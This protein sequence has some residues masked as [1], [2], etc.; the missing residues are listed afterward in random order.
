MRLVPRDFIEESY[1]S[2]MLQL[3]AVESSY[4]IMKKRIRTVQI[5]LVVF[6][7]VIPGIS[8]ALSEIHPSI[9]ATPARLA[10]IREAVSVPGSHHE[11]V[12]SLM[13]ERVESGDWN[14]Y[15]LSDVGIVD[16]PAYSRAFKALEASLTYLITQDQSYADIAYQSLRLIYDDPGEDVILPDDGYGLGRA[17][18]GMSFALCYDWCY[19]AWSGEQRNW[20]SGKIK[21]AINAWPSVSHTH[22]TDLS[23]TSNWV[24]V[25]RGAEMIMI[26]SLGRELYADRYRSIRGDLAIHLRNA[27]CQF[28]IT[29]E[30]LG[31]TKYGAG[32]MMLAALAAEDDGDTTIVSQ[33]RRRRL[34]MFPFYACSFRG[35][36]AAIQTGVSHLSEPLQGYLCAT[37]ETVRDTVLPYYRYMYDRHVGLLAPGE[38][39]ERFNPYR[40][41]PVWS[42]LFYNKDVEP[43]DP[44][45][46]LPRGILDGILGLGV[47][48]T[49]W[50]DEND[51]QVWFHSDWSSHTGW[52][53]PEAFTLGIMG[54]NT[55]F[56]GGP[57]T[58]FDH[59]AFSALT[60]DGKAYEGRGTNGRLLYFSVG[61]SGGYMVAD[62]AGKYD[63]LGISRVYRTFNIDLTKRSG[64]PVLM[65]TLD[66]IYDLEE[67]VYGWQLNIGTELGDDGVRVSASHEN[68]METFL[69][70]GRN[71]GW[72]KGW[73]VGPDDAEV[74]SGDPLRIVTR[75]KSK[76]IW[77]AMVVGDGPRPIARRT[78]HGL[79]ARFMVGGAAITYDTSLQR[80]VISDNRGIRLA[81]EVFE[82]TELVVEKKYG[83]LKYYEG[84]DLTTHLIES[85]ARGTVQ[86]SNDG[87]FRYMPPEDYS[88]PD[89]FIYKVE[90]SSE[91]TWVD[92]V[93]LMIEEINDPPVI[94]AQTPR[95][96][97]YPQPFVIKTEHFTIFDVDGGSEPASFIYAESPRYTMQGDTVYPHYSDS[98]D[99]VIPVRP[100]DGIDTGETFPYVVTFEDRVRAP[101]VQSILPSDTIRLIE[102]DTIEITAEAKD[103]QQFSLAWDWVRNGD[104]LLG[105]TSNGTFKLITDYPD[106][107]VDNIAVR[108]TNVAGLSTSR[109][110]TI[111]TSQAPAPILTDASPSEMTFF[112]NDSAHLWV[113]A[114][115]PRGFPLWYSW[116]KNGTD[117]L[118]STEPGTLVLVPEYGPWTHDT[119]TCIVSNPFGQSAKMN[120]ALT[121][122]PIPNPEITVHSDTYITVMEK[123]LVELSI[124]ALDPRALPLSYLWLKNGADTLSATA[125]DTYRF[126]TRFGD[127]NEDTVT[128]V[129]SNSDGMWTKKDFFITTLREPKAPVVR[130]TSAM[131]V[132]VHEGDSLNMY[133]IAEDTTGSEPLT[134]VW[135]WNGA[136]TMQCGPE[137]RLDRLLGYTSAGKG[138]VVV[139]VRNT[140]SLETSVS[141]YV[142]IRN[143]PLP[144]KPALKDGQ[145]I[146]KDT[147]IRWYWPNGVDPDLDSA[148]IEYALEL[149]LDSTCESET[150]LA[151]VGELDADSVDF[152]RCYDTELYPH[153]R[154]IWFRVA[155]YDG[156]GI[157]TGFSSPVQATYVDIDFLRNPLPSVSGFIAAGPN[158]WKAGV[159]G[160]EFAV[161]PSVSVSALNY[162][163][164][165]NERQ[166][167]S[168]KVYDV[169][170]HLVRTLYNGFAGVG[171]HRV[172]FDGSTDN[173]G[174][175]GTGMYWVRLRVGNK[176]QIR[177][178]VKVR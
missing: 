67:H 4:R 153:E 159:I 48:R 32:T 164:V 44:E 2:I 114:E 38:L 12:F 109:S 167:V 30:G 66:K 96:M 39:K 117:T 112:E 83:V 55:L 51:I 75:G 43:K 152:G 170:G 92:T 137:N 118:S 121:T 59:D 31:Y 120:F 130:E 13:R 139:R 29:S 110:M 148:G 10:V 171:K 177:R 98:G 95:I 142:D 26:I 42:L 49:R 99:F 73:V 17:N 133:V 69:L 37:F 89:R 106:W 15:D 54:Y 5:L 111:I 61:D 127:W 97:A 6:F 174:I 172:V 100:F 134:Y 129:V 107:T 63:A 160:I 78:G 131:G 84:V 62:G 156:F 147:Y 93:D 135:L 155:A 126:T 58:S 7:A 94:V 71:D 115:E 91:D 87:A 36:L 70:E 136:D 82:D 140:D 80:S 8:P 20:I 104:R 22:L 35:G 53:T 52:S 124:S 122:V 60:V 9:L 81:F 19:N 24:P 27:Y 175:L 21:S 68:G 45:L 105:T 72:V 41:S 116:I 90:G 161:S 149:Y 64:Y 113:E 162:H 154:N 56:S 65:S 11:A 40:A 123:D 119:V 108:V 34:W 157:T 77:V 3:D 163:A 46:G 143:V 132:A 169:R 76:N 165:K 86:L 168:I 146:T 145:K 102:G 88:G 74:E 101:I 128:I 14:D 138:T 103:V 150:M 57:G 125:G 47:F 151:R 16:R 166:T 18:T 141:F 85:N 50:K 173:G 33:I 144:P 176:T 25:C 79:E 1:V 158:P 178:I 28:G 23:K